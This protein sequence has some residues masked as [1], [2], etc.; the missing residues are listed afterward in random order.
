MPDGENVRSVGLSNDTRTVL[1]ETGN[2]HQKYAN[3]QKC[4]G[5]YKIE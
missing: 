2:E 5:L 1:D 3:I 4:I